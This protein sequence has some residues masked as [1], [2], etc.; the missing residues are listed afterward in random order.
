V[1][2]PDRWPR[3]RQAKQQFE[4]IGQPIAQVL[5]AVSAAPVVEG[6]VKAKV[7]ALT[8]LCP[9]YRPT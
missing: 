1:S 8:E 3:V 6:K 7:A 9:I 4:T 2:L 5:D